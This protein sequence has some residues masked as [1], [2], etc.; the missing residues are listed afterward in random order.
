MSATVLIADDDPDIL[1]LLSA[2][3]TE[4]GF[5]VAAFSDG[6]AA[7]HALRAERPSVAI[8]DLMMPMMDGRELIEQ[9]RKEPGPPVPVIAMSASLSSATAEMLD[10][11]VYLTKP[12]D[13]EELLAQV[14]YFS[15]R[16]EQQGAFEKDRGLVVET[17]ALGVRT[18]K[19]AGAD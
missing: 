15:S 1:E 11:D 14:S 2:L 13:L 4:E 12:F 16:Q 6:L 9:L 19:S 7:L 5:Q 8:I 18:A 17:A 3:L 10:A